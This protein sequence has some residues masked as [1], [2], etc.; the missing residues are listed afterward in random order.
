MA[1]QQAP[2]RQRGYGASFLQAAIQRRAAVELVNQDPRQE[3]REY[4][5]APLDDGTE[6]IV[7]WWGVSESFILMCVIMPLQ[8]HHQSSYPTLALIARDYLAIQGSSVP[9]ERAFLSAS[10]TDTVLRNRLLPECLGAIQIV[11]S[12]YKNGWIKASEEAESMEKDILV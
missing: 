12:G 11:K 7:C 4:L 5:A 6:D 10:L 8:Q 1:S 3:L 2:A 9:A